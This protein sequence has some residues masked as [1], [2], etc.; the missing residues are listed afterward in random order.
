M[1]N[2]DLCKE[3]NVKSFLINKKNNKSQIAASVRTPYV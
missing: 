3:N 2:S 1:T